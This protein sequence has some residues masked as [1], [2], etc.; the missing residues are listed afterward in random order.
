[1][2]RIL[3]GGLGLLALAGI[4]WGQ[5]VVQNS[6]TGNEVWRAA[7][8]P[9]GPEQWFPINLAR[10]SAA[11]LVVPS[12]SGAVVTTLTTANSTV[13]WVGTAPTTWTVNLPV[14]PFDGEIVTIATDTTLTT[15]VTAVAAAGTS[16]NT[17]YAS[18]TLTAKT[19]V[20]FQYSAGTTKW[21]ELR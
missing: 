10:N 3:Y 13:Y 19:S 9:G 21:Y 15:M 18:Q 2:K 11:L 1:M 17:T 8:G 7:Q 12:T 5:T 6:V 20:E 4:A 14:G 16:L